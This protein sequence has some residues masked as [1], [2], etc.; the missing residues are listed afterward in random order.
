VAISSCWLNHPAFKRRDCCAHC[1]T[2]KVID[3]FAAASLLALS[4]TD[5]M[6]PSVPLRGARP[7]RY[8]STATPIKRTGGRP[9]SAERA[10]GP[11]QSMQAC[12][13]RVRRPLMARIHQTELDHEN[14]S[15]ELNHPGAGMRRARPAKPG[16]HRDACF[17]STKLTSTPFLTDFANR[18][19][20]QFVILTQ[21]CDSDLLTREGSAVP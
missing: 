21:P 17:P 6:A 20:S 7:V 18:S 19:T 9:W 10:N 16:R 1:P 8:I 11:T 2:T 4:T 12:N 15:S 5:T 3:Q 13:F 14:G